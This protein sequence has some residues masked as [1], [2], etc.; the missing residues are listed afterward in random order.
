MK[1]M[2]EVCSLVAEAEENSEIGVEVETVD[3]A[4]YVGC[5]R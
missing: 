2:S 5:V 4:R 3:G 1:A